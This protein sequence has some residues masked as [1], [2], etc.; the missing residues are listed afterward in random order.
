MILAELLLRPPCPTLHAH[1]TRVGKWRPVPGEAQGV[2]FRSI[3]QEAFLSVLGGMLPPLHQ[4]GP[5]CQ[6]R[7]LR[8]LVSPRRCPHAAPRCR[9]GDIAPPR[10]DRR[11][12]LLVRVVR[13]V[14]SCYVDQ[15]EESRPRPPVPKAWYSPAL[16]ARKS[17]HLPGHRPRW[18][19]EA[20]PTILCRARRLSPPAC[21]RFS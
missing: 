9:E 18:S 2:R 1:R 17:E 5:A 16:T 20:C 12:H 21:Q 13:P 7:T 15:R 8:L 10:V 6:H 4:M 14:C 11:P 19:P 3:V